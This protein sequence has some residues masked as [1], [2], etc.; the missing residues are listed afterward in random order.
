LF[1]ALFST[2]VGS[3]VAWTGPSTAPPNGNT[4]SPINVSATA[5]TKTGPF[6]ISLPAAYNTWGINVFGGNYG[7]IGQAS[8]GPGIYGT[9]VSNWGG[10]FTGGY[11]LYAQNSAGY[12]TELDNSSYGLYTNGYIYGPNS[13]GG[14]FGVQSSTGA[15]YLGNPWTGACGCP[16][17]APNA[18]IITN[19]DD[20]TGTWYAGYLCY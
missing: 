6:N 1:V 16:G 20:R 4:S 17:F 13:F 15:C 10:E 12:Y 19:Q 2:G 5:Q 11:G 14:G 7:V 8:A 18:E 3:A 9:S